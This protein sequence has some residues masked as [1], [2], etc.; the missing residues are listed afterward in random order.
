MIIDL[1]EGVD[2]LMH[3][4][5]AM[6]PHIGPAAARFSASV[7]EHTTLGLRESEAARL[8]IA[9][10]NGCALCLDWRAERD[11]D[12][13]EDGFA[14]AVQQWRTARALDERTR[15]AAEYA[16]RWALD[17]EGLDAGFWTRMKRCYTD[18]EIVE[19]T[20]CLGA[21][22]ALGRVNRVLGLDEA[23]TLPE[24]APSRRA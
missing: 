8:R 14:E 2:P 15:L 3:V 9:Q 13:V 17:H 22:L 23:C 7:Q 1:P 16:E 10:V 21:W 11:G 19:L 18:R 20:L 24:H 12:S 6:V 4:W 5:G